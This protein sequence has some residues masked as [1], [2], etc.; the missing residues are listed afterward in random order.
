M[1]YAINYHFKELPSCAGKKTSTDSEV[2]MKN[3]TALSMFP[4]NRTQIL[5]VP[6]SS[7]SMLEFK[8]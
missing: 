5:D 1:R 7:T 8:N 2:S 3:D 6:R 4:I